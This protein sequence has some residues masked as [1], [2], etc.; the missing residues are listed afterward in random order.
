VD[1]VAIDGVAVAD[2]PAAPVLVEVG[3]FLMSRT[4]DARPARVMGPAEWLQA[5]GPGDRSGFRDDEFATQIH[6]DH[7]HIGF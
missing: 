6:R 7:L 2:A 4:G 3:R 5:L 1:I